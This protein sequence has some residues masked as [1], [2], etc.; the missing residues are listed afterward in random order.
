MKLMPV[1]I[2]PESDGLVTPKILGWPKGSHAGQE[3]LSY[4]LRTQ[5]LTQQE[6]RDNPIVLW[7]VRP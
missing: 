7:T 6:F 5:S 1:Q 4:R 3:V 2:G